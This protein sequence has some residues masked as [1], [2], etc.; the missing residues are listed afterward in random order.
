MDDS[1][2][3]ACTGPVGGTCG[4]SPYQYGLCSGSSAIENYR[5]DTQAD[6]STS[7]SAGTSGGAS[8][9]F[10]ARLPS[11]G[12]SASFLDRKPSTGAPASLS[13]RKPSTG[14]SASFSNRKPSIGASAV[15][16]PNHSSTGSS[17]P[18]LS[19]HSSAGAL[20]RPP[21]RVSVSGSPDHP[22]RVSASS[23]PG[24]LSD[25]KSKSIQPKVSIS[26]SVDDEGS[27]RY[28]QRNSQ[29][30]KSPKNDIGLRRESIDGQ[31]SSNLSDTDV[32]N[33]I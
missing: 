10:S 12:P 3:V 27:H 25:S 28:S 7:A 29:K 2:T 18:V 31:M 21:P 32:F 33:F 14:A 6:T 22:V 5:I 4:A 26:P 15:V 8:T 16:S 13:D 9:G 20:V 19:R 24:R 30:D 11:T 1:I 23:S 17:A